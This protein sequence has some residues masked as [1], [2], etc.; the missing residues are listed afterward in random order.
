MPTIAPR[1]AALAEARVEVVRNEGAVDLDV[2]VEGRRG[3]RDRERPLVAGVHHPAPL[4]R[5]PL[6][7]T[8]P[9]LRRVRAALPGSSTLPGTFGPQKPFLET[10]TTIVLARL[11]GVS[12]RL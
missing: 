2:E 9:L 8:V 3:C 7:D 10:V 12:K 11:P 1:S 6:E 4:L 5:H